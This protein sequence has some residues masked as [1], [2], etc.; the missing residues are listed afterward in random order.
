MSRETAAAVLFEPGRPLSIERLAL[1]APRRR[2]VLVRIEAAGCCHSDAHYMTGDLTCP[3]PVVL[4]HEGAGV[5]EEVGDGVELVAAGDR[6]CLMWRPRCGICGYCVVGR[7]QLCVQGR[8]QASTGGLLDGT[9]RWRLG[10]RPVHHFL[11]VSCFAE[12]CVV[13]ERSLVRVPDGVP[14]EVA[15]I[16][17]CAVI[18][19]VGAVTRAISSG[20]GE[21]LVVI[22]CGG[23]G[24]SAVMGAAAAGLSP[25]VAVD[26]NSAARSLA[27]ELGATHTLDTA[28]DT[29]A[30]LRTILPEGADW[31]VDAVGGPATLRLAF[32]C[33]RPGGTAVAVGLARAGATCDV[34]INELVQ[35]EKRLVGSLYG[36]SNPLVDLPR[37][38]ALQQAGKLPIERLIQARRRLDE[39]NEAYEALRAG[40]VGRT[41]LLP[42]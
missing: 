28:D 32:S 12:R 22:G 5:V 42:G 15:A 8:V 25:I 4:G 24:L 10:D 18:T 9:T 40:S 6:V 14:S 34:P 30:A 1:E 17:G 13:S 19:G 33:L 37:L 36:S 3:L 23:V 31:A 26:P 16:A 39:V 7:P 38:F 41:V 20:P 35:Q 11:G 29:R 2:E 21:A 27:C